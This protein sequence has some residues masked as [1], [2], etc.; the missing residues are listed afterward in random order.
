MDILLGA[1][2]AQP[3]HCR[4]ELNF[5]PGLLV[6]LRAVSFN[7][8]SHKSFWSNI[9]SKA[10]SRGLVFGFLDVTFYLEVDQLASQTLLSI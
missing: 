8:I 1:Q 4:Q 5:G 2:L 7:I 9:A 6:I 3:S 10:D